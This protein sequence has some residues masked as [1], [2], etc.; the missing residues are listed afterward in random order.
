M[1]GPTVYPLHVL[2]VC[3]C[4][5]VHAHARVHTPICLCVYAKSCA[6]ALGGRTNSFSTPLMATGGISLVSYLSCPCFPFFMSPATSSTVLVILMHSELG[7]A[8]L[9]CRSIVISLL[10]SLAYSFSH[11]W[12]SKKVESLSP[13]RCSVLSSAASLG[14]MALLAW[15]ASMC[16]SVGWSSAITRDSAGSLVTCMLFPCWNEALHSNVAAYPKSLMHNRKPLLSLQLNA[17]LSA[18]WKW[19]HRVSMT[20]LEQVKHFTMS[21]PGKWCRQGAFV[22]GD[23]AGDGTLGREVEPDREWEAR[24]MLWSVPGASGWT[25]MDDNLLECLTSGEF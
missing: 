3:F 10:F 7:T 15:T 24:S 5:R 23:K 9:T 8:P 6:F 1:C 19:I 16:F 12:R 17:R 21:W 13:E 20:I 14:H 11:P 2:R 25:F 18:A 4:V 22:N